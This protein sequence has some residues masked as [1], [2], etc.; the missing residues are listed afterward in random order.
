MDYTPTNG[1][2][3]VRHL[4]VLV[5]FSIQD[6][7]MLM[8]HISDEDHLNVL[9]NIHSALKHMKGMTNW[10]RDDLRKNYAK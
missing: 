2:D 4:H 1:P 5:D 7:E 9:S 3:A 8:I 10:L 6:L